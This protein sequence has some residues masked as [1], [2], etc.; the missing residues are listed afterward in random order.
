MVLNGQLPS[1][2]LLMSSQCVSGENLISSTVGTLQGKWGVGWGQTGGSE[3][4]T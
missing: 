1:L 3:G 4:F 2:W